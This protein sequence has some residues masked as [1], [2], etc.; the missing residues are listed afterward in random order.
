M[1]SGRGGAGLKGQPDCSNAGAKR[2]DGGLEEPER[3]WSCPKVRRV[4]GS[5]FCRTGLKEGRSAGLFMSPGP[6][7][8][9]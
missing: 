7:C 4:G 9:G 1:G 2:D 5:L 8:P 3:S 6:L